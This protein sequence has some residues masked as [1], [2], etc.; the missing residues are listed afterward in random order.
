MSV[1]G[2]DSNDNFAGA[3]VVAFDKK[4]MEAGA[5]SPAMIKFARIGGVNATRYGGLLPSNFTGTVLPPAGS[6][7]YFAAVDTAGAGAASTFQLLEVSV[8]WPTLPAALRPAPTN[9]PGNT[10]NFNLF[11]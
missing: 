7:N 2:F 11:H 5:P 10:Y 3:T 9:L 8:D 1:N 6:P 4:A